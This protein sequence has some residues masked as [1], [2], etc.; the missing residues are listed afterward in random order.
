[1]PPDPAAA[2]RK[3]QAGDWLRL[4]AQRFGD[5]DCFIDE[6]TGTTH[7]FTET[8][9]RVN[10]LANALTAAGVTKGDRLVI[11]ANDSHRYME[12]LLASMKLGTTYVPLNVRLAA[13][14]IQNLLT[15]SSATWVFASGRYVE[16]ASGLV[17]ID[18]AA[19]RI[20]AYDTPCAPEAAAPAS[21]TASATLAQITMY[22]DLLETGDAVEPTVEV[23]DHDIIGLAFTSGTTGLPKGVLQ[24][25]G[26]IKQMVLTCLIEYETGIDEC[27]YS[28]APMF[29]ISGMAMI[30]MGVLRGYPNVLASQ[31]DPKQVLD[32]LASDRLS[33]CFM[34][35]TMIASV[36][37]QPGAEDHAYERLGSIIYGA[38]PMPPTLLRRAMRTF[39]CDFIQAFGAGTEAGLQ[40]VLTSADH[41]RAIDGAE[42]LLGSIGRPS[43]NVDLR[44]CDD[45]LRDVPRGQV[46]EI[47]TRSDMVMSG[48][49]DNP[50]ASAESLA[51]GWFRAGDLAWMDDEGYLYLSGR[52][53]DM[54]IRGGENVYPIEIETVLFEHQAVKDVAVVGRPDEHWGETVAAYLV[55]ESGQVQPGDDELADFCRSKLARYKVPTTFTWVDAFPL[56]ASGKVLKRELRELPTSET[57]D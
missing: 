2:C 54:I 29:H 47:V 45:D 44:L 31:F 52:K 7:T 43:V 56:N 10:R 57:A 55:L 16:M 39:G 22:E 1:M 27:R 4:S 49:L 20:I 42:H 6:G 32:W 25:Q 15:A 24:S 34:V 8:N 5:R 18:G 28:A 12:T 48:Y 33:A 30:M 19:P 17:T 13:F 51:G 9:E 36:L 40:A 41:R 53:K 50:E 35:P 23:E 3:I 14:E 26:M 38:A 37:D 11:L 46:G 21:A